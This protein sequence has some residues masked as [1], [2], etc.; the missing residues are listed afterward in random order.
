MIPVSVIPPTSALMRGIRSI[1]CYYSINLQTIN[2]SHTMKKI[3]FAFVI[4][5]F[6]AS[7]AT[8]Q[9]L[10]PVKWQFGAKKLNDREAVVFMKATINNGWHIYSQHL[11]EGGP[12]PTLFTFEPASSYT[13]I[14][15]P[16][17]PKPLTKREEVFD[18]D[19]AYFENEVVF[20]QKIKLT[21][22]ATA[23]KGTVEFMACNATQ[24]LPPD[25]ITFTVAV[26]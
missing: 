1:A 4:V 13:L 17:E 26:K 20:Q 10:Q 25:E 21:Q 19:V 2:D 15:K 8:A 7:G 9:I 23:V 14:G 24:C 12:I 3:L 16:A 22:G 18:M 6:A 5:L 11:E